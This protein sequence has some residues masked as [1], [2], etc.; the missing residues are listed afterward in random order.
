MLLITGANDLQSIENERTI[1]TP[2]HEPA[3]SF[4]F[5]FQRA[6]LNIFRL[7]CPFESFR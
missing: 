4:D 2:P 3:P 7:F 1:V 5:Y 6:D